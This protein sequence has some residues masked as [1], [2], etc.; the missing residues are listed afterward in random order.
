MQFISLDC[1][2]NSETD[3]KMNGSALEEKQF[4]RCC[5]WMRT[6]GWKGPIKQ[7]VIP[8][9]LSLHLSDIFLV[10]CHMFF[11]NFGMV[12]ET[13]V[14]LCMTELDFAEKVIFFDPKIGEMD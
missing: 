14:N 11:Q 7:S 8:S 5:Y 12:L 13:H 9:C 4:L 6:S 10:F 3:V 1:L 2:N